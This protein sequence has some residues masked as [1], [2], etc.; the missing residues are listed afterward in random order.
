[1]PLRRRST[2][3]KGKEDVEI[4]G[5]GGGDD[6]RTKIKR[7]FSVCSTGKGKVG[8]GDGCWERKDG[9]NNNVF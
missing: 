6:R 3:A 9:R 8:S 7:E 4:V 2:I 1:M 5:V